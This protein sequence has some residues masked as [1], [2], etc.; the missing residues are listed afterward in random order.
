MVDTQEQIPRN[1]YLYP[2]PFFAEFMQISTIGELIS[3][4]N[5]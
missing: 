4:N 3:N 1:M 5:G 2:E